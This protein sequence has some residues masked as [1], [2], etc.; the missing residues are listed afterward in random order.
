MGDIH[1][2]RGMGQAPPPNE[3]KSTPYGLGNGPD[4]GQ[5]DTVPR[6]QPTH[7]RDQPNRSDAWSLKSILS[8]MM[9]QH[10]QPG[11]PAPLNRPSVSSTIFSV[12]GNVGTRPANRLGNPPAAAIMI[13]FDQDTIIQT[14]G[15]D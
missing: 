3:M 11:L 1:G 12:M 5:V 14:S 10:R 6:P 13:F 9:S 4:R 15:D 2:A 8:N 7:G